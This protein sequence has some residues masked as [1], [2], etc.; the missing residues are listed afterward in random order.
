MPHG[1]RAAEAMSGDR[2]P[3]L[4]LASDDPG[5]PEL[6]GVRRPRAFTASRWATAVAR[7]IR[8]L[9]ARLRE[10]DRKCR[11][12][13]SAA[14]FLQR[15]SRDS[16]GEPVR[17]VPRGVDEAGAEGAGRRRDPREAPV[18]RPRRH[19]RDPA[20]L[21]PGG[22]DALPAALARASGDR[23]RVLPLPAVLAA[24]VVVRLRGA[25]EPVGLPPSLRC[26]LVQHPPSV[27]LDLFVHRVRREVDATGPTDDA[28]LDQDPSELLRDHEGPRRP[29]DCALPRSIGVMSTTP[30]RAV[31]ERHPKGGVGE[32]RRRSS[33]TQGTVNRFL[34]PAREV[35][36]V[37]EA[38]WHSSNLMSS[39]DGSLWVFR[40][41][42]AQPTPGPTVRSS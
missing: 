21:F 34:Q 35:R 17:H 13:G 26:S 25:R 19:Q 2:R 37:L 38:L 32:D 29:L 40:P 1:V 10:L 24:R 28:A 12:K 23:V 33:T 14:V 11:E 15:R 5:L 27:L 8:P 4:A 7:P 3:R 30:R 18:T 20:S 41:R 31:D 9:C 42:A 6:R 36:F 22:P 16:G 39:S